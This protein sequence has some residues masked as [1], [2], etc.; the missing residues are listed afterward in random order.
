MRLSRRFKETT[1]DK[2]ASTAIMLISV[3]AAK[4]LSNFIPKSLWPLGL[5][6]FI[7]I[8]FVMFCVLAIIYAAVCEKLR[9]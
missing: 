6:S 3:V 8:G 1:A 5:L 7:L 2:I 4:L 9:K